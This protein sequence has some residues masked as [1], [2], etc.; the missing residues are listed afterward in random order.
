MQLYGNHLSNSTKGGIRLSY[1]KNPLGVRQQPSTSQQQQSLG[2]SSPASNSSFMNQATTSAVMSSYSS[3]SSSFFG[4]YNSASNNNHMPHRHSI[5]E[6]GSALSNYST[7]S[8]S[9]TD[10]YPSNQH[11]QSHHLSLGRHSATHSPSSVGGMS[12][13]AN[14]LPPSSSEAALRNNSGFLSPLTLSLLSNEPDSLTQQ[15]LVQQS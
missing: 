10:I 12:G 2:T 4:Y 14:V 3:N 6:R 5:S 8:S 11:V 7:L 1:S 9:L 13:S 15:R